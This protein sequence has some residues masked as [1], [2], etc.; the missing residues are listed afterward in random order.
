MKKINEMTIEDYLKYY[1]RR[2]K[3]EK[4]NNDEDLDTYFGNENEKMKKKK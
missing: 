4:D 1:L 3:K 2:E